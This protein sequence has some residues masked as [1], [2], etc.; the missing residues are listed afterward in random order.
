MQGVLTVAPTSAQGILINIGNVSGT[1]LFSLVFFITQN[2]RAS[3]YMPHRLI[4]EGTISP[5]HWREG[6]NSVFLKAS[7]TFELRISSRRLAISYLK[8]ESMNWEKCHSTTTSGGG[9][10]LSHGDFQKF[11]LEK[12][13]F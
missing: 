8:M 7:T 10:M 13:E 5:P 6:L 4:S 1:C 11:H 3:L 2:I 12:I 9:I